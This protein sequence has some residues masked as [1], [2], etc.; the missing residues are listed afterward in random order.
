MAGTTINLSGTVTP[1]GA[2][3]NVG[4]STSATTGPGGLTTATVTGTTWT[5]SI[6]P[7][8]AGTYYIW[9]ESG[10]AAP[11]VS[12]AVTVSSS[13][14]AL[15]W[16]QIGSTPSGGITGITI[17]NGYT[18]N[19]GTPTVHGSS[20]TP[21]VALTVA[22]G[23]SGTSAI[24]WYDSNSTNTSSTG[25]T[26]ASGTV[27]NSIGMPGGSTAVFSPGV[28]PATPGTYYAKL[29]ITGTGTDAGTYI[30]TSQAITVT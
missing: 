24:F 16:T 11:A 30:F 8:T 20:V 23:F 26:V 9:A 3:V 27:N 17:F 22:T 7:S 21:D 13:Q 12:A 18:A 25:G 10:A 5:V 1:S 6:I 15:T 4:L 19:L 14:T 29:S 2:A 28:A